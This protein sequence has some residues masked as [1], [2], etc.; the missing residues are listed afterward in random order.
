MDRSEP[1]ER[2]QRQ[3]LSPPSLPHVSQPTTNLFVYRTLLFDGI[4]QALTDRTFQSSPA[5]LRGFTRHAIVR[6]GETEAYPAIKPHASA[7]VS[8]RVFLDVDESSASLIDAFEGDPPDYQAAPVAVESADGRTITATTYVALPGLVPQ[9]DG[10]WS[11]QEFQRLH[12]EYYVTRVIP[13]MRQA[14]EC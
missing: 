4:V 11:E 10:T 8:G 1:V 2:R 3:R 7:G 12:L 9:L 5:L 13:E 14:L 6:E